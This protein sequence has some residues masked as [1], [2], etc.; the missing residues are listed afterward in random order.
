MD[1]ITLKVIYYTVRLRKS[2]HDD[3]DDDD[4]QFRIYLGGILFL[5]QIY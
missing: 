2:D 1:K 3:E 5:D 4:D